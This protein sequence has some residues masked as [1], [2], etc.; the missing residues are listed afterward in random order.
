[1]KNK[2]KCSERAVTIIPAKHPGR[3]SE[4]KYVESETGR[5]TERKERG[6]E[7]GKMKAPRESWLLYNLARSC[8]CFS[9]SLARAY[10]EVS[11]RGGNSKEPQRLVCLPG[12]TTF[13]LLLLGGAFMTP[14]LHS[15]ALAFLFLA[16]LS[17]TCPVQVPET[18]MITPWGSPWEKLVEKLVQLMLAF[19]GHIVAFFATQPSFNELHCTQC[20]VFWSWDSGETRCLAS[21][22]FRRH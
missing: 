7:N 14:S 15:P 6:A 4:W 12:S 18:R 3:K 20:S 9:C 10:N 13:V 21:S 17:S 19:E 16:S 5:N 2:S 11:A 8:P 1:M 22:A